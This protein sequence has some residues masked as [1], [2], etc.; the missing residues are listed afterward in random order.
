MEYQFKCPN[1]F[2]NWTKN[3]KKEPKTRNLKCIYCRNY[4]TK[5]DKERLERMLHRMPEAHPSDLP[6]TLS[7]MYNVLSK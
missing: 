2:W 3:V 5:N 1:C 6:E 4:P 7:L